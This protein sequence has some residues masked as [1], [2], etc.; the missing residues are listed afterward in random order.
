MFPD[1]VPTWHRD[2]PCVGCAEAIR[3]SL[4]EGSFRISFGAGISEQ[5]L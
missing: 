2:H 5:E 4:R 1:E 3:A